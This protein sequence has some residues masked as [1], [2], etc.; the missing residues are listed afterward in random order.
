MRPQNFVQI[1]I[2][3]MV[4]SVGIIMAP[5]GMFVAGRNRHTAAE[6]AD[7]EQPA[8]FG[9]S[10]SETCTLTKVVHTKERDPFDRA[11]AAL[12]HWKVA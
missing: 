9:S 12:S 7:A 2:S 10:T 1:F 11:A 4:A 5:V 3:A 8:G 6:L